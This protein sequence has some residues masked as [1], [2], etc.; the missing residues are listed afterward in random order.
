MEGLRMNVTKKISVLQALF[1]LIMAVGF[2]NH[3]TII[4][5]LLQV[6]FRDSWISVICAYLLFNAWI[7]IP[8]F[9]AKKT[10]DLSL[11]DWLTQNLGKWAA[12][13]FIWPFAIYLLFIA[14]IT[15]KETINW[16]NI[17]YLPQTPKSVVAITFILLC[18]YIAGSGIRPIAI[19]AG[20]LL[21]LVWILGYF[22]MTANFTYKDYSKMFPV[23]TQGLDPIL[24]AMVYAG[25]GFIEV[26]ILI[27]IRHH[28]SKPLRLGSWLWLAFILLGLTLGPLLG[29]IA[30]Y[31]P[32]ESANQRFPAFEQWRLVV[33][34][35]YIAHV[36]FLALYQWL[37]GAFIRITLAL[38]I[39]WDW[40]KPNRKAA[41]GSLY[42]L[43]FIF[44]LT[45]VMAPI[46]DIKFV[47]WL[48]MVY[49]PSVLIAMLFVSSL[50][51]G[52]VFMKSRSQRR[53]KS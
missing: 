39:I 42:V 48:K 10:G 9:I 26:F 12:R 17:T 23:F 34:G 20:L 1:I 51:A 13:L 31:G 35:K 49:Y 33:I 15:L 36:D 21:P 18:L 6:G 53:K 41:K 40:I 46:S 37:S 29:A 3:V 28:I 11:P 22:V 19:T 52:L 7:V 14:A 38:Y 4:P 45:I 50:L 25:G 32:V 30:T 5:L 43:F 24:H 2:S 44:L 16:V 47:H 8:Y 27:F